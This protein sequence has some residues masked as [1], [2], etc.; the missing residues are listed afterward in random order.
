[1]KRTGYRDGAP[2]PT[3]A[4][5]LR[6]WGLVC[7]A[8]AVAAGAARATVL[9]D[10]DEAE[11]GDFF[12]YA[13]AG[14]EGGPSAERRAAEAWVA[15]VRE[16]RGLEAPLAAVTA[17]ETRAELEEPPLAAD[18][19]RF[20]VDEEEGWIEYLIKEDTVSLYRDASVQYGD[21]TLTADRIRFYSGRDLLVAEGYCELVDPTQTLLGVRMS[22]DL[23]SEKGVVLRGDAESEQGYYAGRRIKKIEEKTIAASRGS[24][25]TCDLGEPHYHFWSPRL[26]VYAEDKVVARPAVL[27][28]GEVPI[29]AAPFYFFSLR[30]DRHSGFLPP[31]IRYSQRDKLTVNNGF[32]WVINDFSDAT[33]LL[34][35]NALM[36]WRKAANV[37]YL[38]GSRSTVNN[39]YASHMRQRDRAE[40][41][42][43]IYG[44]HRQ[45]ISDDAAA[46]VRLDFRNSTSYDDIIEEDF[47]IRTEQRLESFVNVTQNWENY[48]L[49]VDARQTKEKTRVAGN[50]GGSPVALFSAPPHGAEPVGGTIQVT[51]DPFPRVNFYATRQELAATRFYY[52]YGASAVNYY[53]F[54]G[55]GSV[56][57]E[58]E[59]DVST[60]RPLTLFR[61]LRVDPG[62]A[63]HGYWYDRDKF[64]RNDRFL[65]TWD[66]TLSLST[67]IY[68]I[69]Q[70][71]DTVLRHIV[72][73][74][75][76]HN[77]RPDIDQ[78]WMVTGGAV[79]PEQSTLSLALRQS[80]DVKLPEKEEEKA[81]AAEGEKEGPARSWEEVYRPS[82][83]GMRQGRSES[84]ARLRKAATVGK[85]INLAT[86][87]T[88]TSYN[89]GPL[90]FPGARPFSDLQNTIEL[91]PNFREEYFLSHRLQ[92]TNDF[93]S[94]RLLDF[95]VSTSVSFTT[96]A[97][98][99]GRE[100]DESWDTARD[101]YGRPR[102][103]GDED[104]DP[105]VYNIDTI[106]G[107][108]YEAGEGMGQGWNFSFTHDYSWSS[109]GEGLEPSVLHAAKGAF[110]F[111][112]TK[113]WRLGYDV[114]YD[115]RE[116]SL[117]SQHYRIFRNLHRWEAELRVAFE[118]NDL[119]YWFQVRLIDI[120]EIE[121]YGT[122]TRSLAPY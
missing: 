105:N 79:Y 17:E 26:K 29:A 118:R 87:D 91:T 41:W 94:L 53:D 106:T 55:A 96:G 42:W 30:K 121:L 73:P 62:A 114:Y 116:G 15:E 71:G 100:G 90:S 82:R 80:L 18:E 66:T 24:F 81:G 28:M 43:K 113:K 76:T 92:F 119:I 88:S 52:Q 10:P 51:K 115:I 45:D 50:A 111:D 112:L 6:R 4:G 2:G 101:P 16:E 47:E 27:F 78:S 21:M 122:Q 11:V 35:Y 75:A 1:V 63:G 61:Y 7:A 109:R 25:T 102:E 103:T 37:V 72:N 14:E 31:Y 64:G 117:I 104:L 60:S 48:Q 83:T 85:V 99:R 20:G 56:L 95:D 84:V 46:L 86:W 98:R 57:K 54:E 23:E 58:G 120:P 70:S 22:Y 9:E 65:G 13:G 12:K 97:L 69:F 36:G 34:D 108:R 107:R 19:V 33:F 74:T 49:S 32:Y 44:T 59:A 68:G 3:L 89:M 93:Y 5:G 8:L 77:Y 40:E 110:S 38:Y 67:K 39:F